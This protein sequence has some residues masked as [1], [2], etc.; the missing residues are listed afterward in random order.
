MFYFLEFD[1][2]RIPEE[3]TD[4][5]VC[6]SGIGGLTVALT[7]KELGLNPLL[8]TRGIGNTYY[9]QGGIACAI[10]EGDSPELHFV[11][12]IRAGRNLNDPRA[13]RILVEE[14]L[15][16]IVKLE[17]WGVS[18]DKDDKGYI[19]TTEGGHSVARVLKVKDYTGRAIYT[20]L[21]RRLKECGIPVVEGELQEILGDDRV[22][23]ILVTVE[24][25]LMVIRLKA[26]VLATG[27]AASIFR[28]TTNP[29]KARG[30]AIGIAMRKG[31]R[32]RNPE[33]IQ[34]HPTVF[35]D[36][37]LLISEAVR[38]EGAFLVDDNGE[39]FVNELEPRDVVARAIYRKMKEGR[40]VFLDM[41]KLGEKIK[42]EDRFPTIFSFLREKGFDPYKDLIPVN[43]A[44]HYFIG[45][46]DVDMFGKTIMEGLYAVGE[47]ACT[48]VHG[49][50]RLA[51]N[52]LLEGIVFGIRTA[53]R[54]YMDINRLGFSEKR[55]V[56][57]KEKT[58]NRDLDFEKI[59]ERLWLMMG[60]ERKGEDLKSLLED[61]DR[62]I[63]TAPY[64]EP[65]V[66]N[67][68]IFDLLLIA[69]ACTYCAYNRKESR[70]VHYRVDFPYEREEFR[71]DSYYNLICSLA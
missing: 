22:E 67:R 68:R 31:I 3:R 57:R 1:T 48:G 29:S 63:D 44:A 30:D 4:I 61:L 17:R 71:K 23:G 41:R 50:N 21:W 64:W 55:Y 20:S 11:D 5:V 53:Y 16:S 19:T 51:S 58:V 25:K 56:F 27:G 7:L 46:I 24:G 54:I 43:P 70:G 38:G 28:Y 6:G 15:F 35:K 13:V 45:G 60:V 8:L 49:A 2:L 14:G 36:S 69:R 59:R 42:L 18:F 32:I 62:V 10:G 66:E 40:Q 37:N 34:F 9:S 12:T 47:C 33:F 39:R 52:S 26:L 65:T